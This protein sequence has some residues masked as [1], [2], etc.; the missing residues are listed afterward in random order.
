MSERERRNRRGAEQK[1]LIKRISDVAERRKL[2]QSPSEVREQFGQ[3]ITRAA[4]NR[5]LA[6]PPLETGPDIFP[7]S[8]WWCRGENSFER[9]LPHGIILLVSPFSVLFPIS[10]CLIFAVFSVTAGAT[11]EY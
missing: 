6:F 9:F 4:I 7:L 1:T 5:F 11:E 3:I 8:E 10:E 2:L